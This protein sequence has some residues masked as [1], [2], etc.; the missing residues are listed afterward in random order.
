MGMEKCWLRVCPP[1]PPLTFSF[2]GIQWYPGHC[3]SKCGRNISRSTTSR[4]PFLLIVI[5]LYFF[6]GGCIGVTAVIHLGSI[7][8]SKWF[9][10]SLDCKRS[11][12]I[13]NNERHSLNMDHIIKTISNDLFLDQSSQHVYFRYCL[14]YKFTHKSQSNA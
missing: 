1:V 5:K 10:F 7:S 11:N 6:V 12:N 8:S 14:Q 13:H 4:P 9:N 2:E 3:C